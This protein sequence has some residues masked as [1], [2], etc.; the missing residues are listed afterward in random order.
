MAP[1]LTVTQIRLNNIATCL[2]VTADTLEI[3]TSSLKAPFLEAI[4]N[5]TKSLLNNIQTVKQNRNACTELMEQTYQL[6]NA[7]LMVHINSDTGGDLPPVVL[8]H[9]GKFTET[10][11]KIHT[12]V[13]AQQTGNKVKTFFRQH[14][15]G[16][17][18][19]DCRLGL[20]REFDYFQIK[21]GSIMSDITKLEEDAAKRQQEVLNM[22]EALSTT[23][24]SDR[25]SSFWCADKQGLFRLLQ[26]LQLIHY[27]ALRAKYIPWAGVRTV[28]DSAASE[29]G[30]SMD[31]NLRCWWDGQNQPS[32]SRGSSH[33]DSGKIRSA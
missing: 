30:H 26:Q 8:N 14:E 23:S 21:T 9:I 22:I 29:A 31:S 6:L 10:L 15:M 25:G 7:I 27:A 20:E 17:L 12:F 18:L 5:T 1:Q 24:D 28:R 4:S 33:R 3:L 19:K 13:E 2:T 32:K 16:A 11:H